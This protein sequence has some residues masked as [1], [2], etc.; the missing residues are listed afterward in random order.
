MPTSPR[1]GPFRTVPF[2][3]ER[4][5]TLDTLRLARTRHGVPILLEV[6]VTAAR[7]A[8]RA[9][10]QGT[11]RPLGFTAWIVSCVARAAAEHPRVHALRRG[12]R[13]LVLFREVDVAV[14]V[15]RGVGS[16]DG[17]ETLP[18]PVV[19]RRAEAKHPSA[20][21]RELR[22][23]QE[24]DVAGG[25]ASIE[26]PAA[27][28]LQSLFFRLP[29]WLRDAVLWRPLLAD[30]HRF[31]RT[32]GTVIVTS[33]GMTTPGILAWGIPSALHPL[34][35]GVGGVQTRTH[36]TETVETLALTVVFDH[37]VVD[38][39]PVGRFVRRLHGLL[40]RADL[41]AAEPEPAD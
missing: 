3:P 33:V 1:P 17:G 28:W 23:A 19:V 18:M 20:I 27:P 21:Q 41:P 25:S 37:T 5:A 13:E 9:Y 7:A 16:P 24:V 29:W 26:A 14:I 36:G 15:E 2:R 6:D 40:S 35:I 12:R 39:A 34:A 11:G 38:G 22:R 32:M 4:N 30:P 10:R 31:Q 8:L